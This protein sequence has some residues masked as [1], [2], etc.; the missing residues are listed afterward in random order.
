MKTK[1][2]RSLITLAGLLLAVSNAFG[3][4]SN[5]L[6]LQQC[7]DY[8]VAHNA[9]VVK[10]DLET[11]KTEFMRDEV[12]AAYLPQVN[13]NVQL[14]DNLK[15]QTMLLPGEFVGQPGTKVPVQFGTL[16]N[17]TAGIDATQQIF[18]P[19]AIQAMKI[20][21]QTQTINSLNQQK[22]RQQLT[23]DIANAY[24]AAQIT[25][26]QRNL[27]EANL[28]KID[29]LLQLTTVQ[30]N[31]DFA[32]KVDVD[33]LQV[34][35]T[36][37]Q[38]ELANSKSNYE[39]QLMML[40]FYMG[41]PLDETIAVPE[42][43]MNEKASTT[44]VNPENI[45]NVDSQLLQAQQQLN[46]LNIKQIRSGYLPTLSMTFH[47]AEQFQQNDLRIFGKDANWYPQTYLAFNLNV[48]I[49]DGLT[50]RSKVQQT[51]IQ[52]KQL[53]ADQQYLNSSIK[54][55]VAN[56]VNKL[57]VSLSSLETQKR[58][59]ELANEVYKTTQ[60]QYQNDAI[61]LSELVNAEN[62]LRVAQ[63]N[64]LTAL[65]QARMAELELIKAT[66]NYNEIK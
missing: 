38:T 42:I 53:E 46:E 59:I 55:Q 39:Q 9:T 17:L 8:G 18:N 36:N 65:I 41:M 10:A 43:S 35:L 52:M 49:F 7:I 47:T 16:Y 40:K 19:G 4:S 24:Y 23:Y 22:T 12:R 48:P 44:L 27:I 51:Q 56:S 1:R 20:A 6:S 37:L 31:N 32:K 54:M 50:K 3:Q 58:N 33:R 13:G 60:V 62:E 34:N 25:L 21:N 66:G 15:L 5:P 2:Q 14:I 30:F 63:T 61:S 45:S 11:Q 64:Y 28:N 57:T 26:T 29:T